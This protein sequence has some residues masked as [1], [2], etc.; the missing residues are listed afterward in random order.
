MS[1]FFISYGAENYF[2]VTVPSSYANVIHNTSY[3]SDILN[4]TVRSEENRDIN[5]FE[6][7]L[8]F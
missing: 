5:V 4:I 6:R 2:P 1:F 8:G 7:I 3:L